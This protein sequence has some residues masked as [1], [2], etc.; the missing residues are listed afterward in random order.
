MGPG[1]GDRLLGQNHTARKNIERDERPGLRFEPRLLATFGMTRKSNDGRRQG[2][3]SRATR[4][5]GGNAAPWGRG[6][7]RPAKDRLHPRSGHRKGGKPGEAPGAGP[8]RPVP[9]APTPKDAERIAK[10]IARAGLCSRR[11][12]E[13]WIAAG[14]VAVNGAV[15]ASPALNV[16]P[17]DRISVDGA[18]LPQRERT[19][20]FL[21][22]KPRG[23]VTTTSDP[24][25]RSTIFD[26]LP[27]D[28]PRLLSVGRLD[29][30]T[31]GLLL[32]TNDG[33]LA[34]VLELPQTG[35]LRRY[36]VRAHGRI[37][38][39][40]LDRLR[41]G[42]EI[43]GVRYGPIEATLD[44]EQGS[45]VWLTFAI[46]EGKN[47]EVR[48]V[49]AHLGL[50]VN[51]LIR[52]SF[53]PFQLGELDRA[54]PGCTRPAAAT[55]PARRGAGARTPMA[56]GAR[57]AAHTRADARGTA[58]RLSQRRPTPAGSRRGAHGGELQAAQGLPP[59]LRARL[60]RTRARQAAAPQVPGRAQR[61]DAGVRTGR[62]RETHRSPHR[63]QG[64]SGGRRAPRPEEARAAAPAPR[65]RG[66]ARPFRRP[67]PVAAAIPE[68]LM[69]IVGG[70]LRG[71]TLA[72]PKS[73]AIRPTADR[74]R[75]SLFNILTHAYGD[76]V[77]GARVLDLFAGTGAL[78]F[79]AL[80]RGAAFVL[81]VDDG[82]E[83]RALLRQNVEALG[84][85]AATRV[86]RR[87]ATRLGAAHPLAPFDLAF[88]DPPYGQGLAERALAAAHAGA[89]L[90]P[91][92]L[93]VVEEATSA[94]FAVP[95]GF[96]ELE[97][98]TY[99]DSQVVF[100]RHRA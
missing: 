78:G 11:D 10:V 95:D 75:E 20:L 23:L 12:A 97:R 61:A 13:E 74:L 90:T 93:V 50:Q 6:K 36:R 66:A 4:T 91:D 76:P 72:A 57:A 60:A 51:R 81:F 18:P 43:D 26:A 1:S 96:E 86:F 5:G 58:A 87:D 9:L 41:G 70:R 15:I 49:L 39:A 59:A 35:W 52:I 53:G 99:D 21:Y 17:N 85:G 69:R 94:Q 62:G 54:G 33:G 7:E 56:R 28:L 89:W 84:L 29:I 55:R 16:T 68:G 79:E 22:H 48:N 71:R 24:E 3:P 67:A 92:A 14:R 32:L 38:Q 34:R 46:R 63:P 30:G 2:P 47:R 83:A 82:A 42:V 77:G 44:R 64:P 19:R 100:L 73:Q 27:K 37:T 40:D 25:G 88:L 8:S 98:R 45:N 65:P 31:E 80:S